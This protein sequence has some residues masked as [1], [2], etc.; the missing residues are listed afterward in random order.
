[1]KVFSV[2]LFL[3]RDCKIV[4]LLKNI[5]KECMERY[6]DHLNFK[7]DREAELSKEGR[8]VEQEIFI[9]K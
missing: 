2:D 4:G 1:M 7:D 3:L 6:F 8:I 9:K 5:R